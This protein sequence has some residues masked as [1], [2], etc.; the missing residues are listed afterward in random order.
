MRIVFFGTPEF[1]LSS[2]DLLHKERYEIAAVVTA[3][4]KPH[5]RGRKIQ[6]SPVK[7]F[8]TD[9]GIT[10]LQP[11]ALDDDAF[12]TQLRNAAPDVMVV[13]AYRILPSRV[14]TLPPMGAFNLHASL[15]PEYRGAAPIHWAI[16]RG[17][18]E[19]GVT[20]FYLQEKVDTG[21]I[22]LQERCAIGE[23][24]TAGELYQRLSTLGAET[25]LGT[26]RMIERGNVQTVQQDDARA[27]AAPKL[28]KELCRVVW[29]RPARVVHNLV[30]GLSPVPAAF[31]LFGGGTVKLYRTQV[32]DETYTGARP[33]T[34]VRADDELHV[35]AERGIVRILELQR[36][37][38]NRMDAAAFIRGS[39]ITK[40]DAFE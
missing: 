11:D 16:I 18:T 7:K 2:L 10:V 31:T 40:G 34:I 30:R 4:D 1:S 37:G 21:N 17:E 35:A 9:R 25:V 19:T 33:G 3:P 13:V 36:S 8:A 12:I 24:E 29:K 15:L 38:K 39:A 32:A 23:N 26:L 14:Y 5:G 28:T 20:T 6:P 22:I 27:S